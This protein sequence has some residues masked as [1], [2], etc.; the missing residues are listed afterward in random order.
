MK[1]TTTPKENWSECFQLLWLSLLVK[2]RNFVE[3]LKVAFRYYPNLTF[4]KEDQSLL[5][6]Y[7]FKSP[8]RISKE[9]MQRRGEKDI[10]VYGETPLT[11][12]DYIA[13]ICG[14]TRSDIVYELGSGRGRGCFWLNAFVHCKAVGI[15]FIPEFV[16]RALAVKQSLHVDG[17]D[18]V[19]EDMLTADYDAAT[20][21]YLYG[22]CFDAV[23]IKKLIDRFLKVKSG[24]KI[25]TVSYTLN[26][27]THQPLFEVMKRFPA[28]FTWGEADVY[29][30]IKK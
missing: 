18:F 20:V 25:I 22:T 29:L 24:T 14:I 1:K 10:H 8:F 26:D 19:C 6:R 9:F 28:M 12:L 4:L 15:E 13:E 16:Q 17:V 27:Y 11:T 30:H 7:F 3:F 5:M 23:F 21:F 2:K